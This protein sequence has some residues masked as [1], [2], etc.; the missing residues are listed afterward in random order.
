[1]C[2][3]YFQ[4]PHEYDG[5]VTLSNGKRWLEIDHIIP[6]TKGGT[7]DYNNKQPLCNSCNSRKHNKTL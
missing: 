6:R 4:P 5:K 7:D 3:L 1:M 2:G